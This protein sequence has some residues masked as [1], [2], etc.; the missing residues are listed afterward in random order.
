M[1]AGGL[2][3]LGASGLSGW[4][5][6]ATV[7]VVHPDPAALVSVSC[8]DSALAPLGAEDSIALLWRIT[9]RTYLPGHVWALGAAT[10]K[11]C[12]VSR[13]RAS[14]SSSLVSSASA[15]FARA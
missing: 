12:C 5:F 10:C 14:L 8:H 9:L 11:R 6:G 4:L 13:D 2:G 7:G 1:Y 15:A 3:W